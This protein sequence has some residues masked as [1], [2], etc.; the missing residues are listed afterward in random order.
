MQVESLENKHLELKNIAS[1]W[2]LNGKIDMTIEQLEIMS[3]E[4][5]EELI[6]TV[7]PPEKLQRQ[8]RLPLGNTHEEI[9][10]VNDTPNTKIELIVSGG[11]FFTT[12]FYGQNNE[13]RYY[14]QTLSSPNQHE[15]SYFLDKPLDPNKVCKNRS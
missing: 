5:L 1:Q 13:R 6:E 8:Y 12:W 9:N 3:I 15:D 7:L 2:I 10:S 11:G 14:I 4:E